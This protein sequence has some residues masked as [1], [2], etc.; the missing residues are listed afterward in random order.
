MCLANST[1]YKRGSRT[2]HLG[3]EMKRV[4]AIKAMPQNVKPKRE[5]P[6]VAIAAK[7]KCNVTFLDS[8]LASSGHSV[9]LPRFN[10]STI[11]SDLSHPFGATSYFPV[12]H[13]S[14]EDDESDFI[15]MR[16]SQGFTTPTIL[17]P[18]GCRTP[19]APKYKYEVQED[20][21]MPDQLMLPVL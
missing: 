15:P 17:K 9:L 6:P 4:A 18:S 10:K 2:A 14:S 16:T 13:S 1:S 12:C 5:S 21:F 8:F 20:F 3:L 7:P 19:L 11:P